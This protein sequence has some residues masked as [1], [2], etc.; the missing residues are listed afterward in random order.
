MLWTS[1]VA[2]FD[3]MEERKEQGTLSWHFVGTFSQLTQVIPDFA[4]LLILFLFC[5]LL[6]NLIFIARNS[7]SKRI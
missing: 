5:L 4:I 1:L 6:K 7:E 2:T 3:K